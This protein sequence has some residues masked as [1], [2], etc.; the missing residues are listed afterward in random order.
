MRN[1]KLTIQYDGTCYAGWQSQKNARAIQEILERALKNITGK[2]A[3][4][5]GSGRTDAGVHAS[6]QIANFK[7]CSKIPLKNLQKALNSNLPKD[8]VVCGTEEVDI[9]FNAQHDAKAKVY[10][11]TI[12]NNDF[13]DPFVRR[14]AAKC[15]FKL[16]LSDMRKAG[17]LMAGRHDFRAFQSKDEKNM[18]KNSIRTIKSLSI[19]KNKDMIYIYIKGDGFLY[20][21]VR[22]MV[23]TLVDVGRGKMS[24]E[25]V[26]DMLRN[27]NRRLCGPTMPAKGLC[28]VGV[29]Y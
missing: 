1:I 13:M 6:A 2:K 29:E 24:L 9:N 17:K 18:P 23:G 27:G 25:T 20:N 10:R 14:F 11:Y 21:M 8:I 16:N 22:G 3:C 7:T 4:L 5:T 26:K 19:A 15:F 12:V 28:L